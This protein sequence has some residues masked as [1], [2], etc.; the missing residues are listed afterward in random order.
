MKK[1][2]ALILCLFLLAGCGGGKTG[3]ANELDMAAASKALDDSYT[4]MI[5][6]DD[7]Q[8]NVVYGLDLSLLEEYVIKCS[9]D[10]NGDFYA[11]LKVSDS[12]KKEVKSQMN[13]LF[14][15]LETQSSMYTPEA[16]A[17]IKN[18]LETSVGSYLIYLV[19]KDT[20]ALYESIKGFIK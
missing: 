2:L 19:G 11:L 14:S 12:N 17:L 5:V 7:T 3:P 20:K 6:M 10:N 16:V 9:S 18:H 4:N 13:N 8:L 15:V 1:A